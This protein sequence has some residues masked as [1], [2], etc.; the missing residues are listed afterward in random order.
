[1]AA[2]FSAGIEI[3][4]QSDKGTILRSPSYVERQIQGAVRDRAY[5]NQ[6]S[7]G[8]P[9]P[10]A[11]QSRRGTRT[12]TSLIEDGLRPVVSADRNPRKSKRVL[13]RVSRASGGPMPG[14]ELTDF[15]ALQ[16]M[17]DLDSIR[18]MT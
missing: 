1:M 2:D 13:P 16:E 10:R 14:I 4:I 3:V 8:P 11:T 6:T 9:Q 18:R 15:S 7:R 12:L 5:H 17:D